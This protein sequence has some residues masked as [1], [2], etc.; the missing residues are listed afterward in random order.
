MIMF[1]RHNSLYRRVIVSVS[2]AVLLALPAITVGADPVPSGEVALG[3][4]V[5]E[6]AYNY[7]DGSITYLLTPSKAQEKANPHTVAPLYLVVYPSAVSGVIG[8]MSCQHQPMDNCPDHG[9]AIS[10]LAMATV[11][12][13]YA[14][15]VWGHDHLI[16]APPS[17]P[18]AGNFHVAWQP[19]VVLFLNAAASSTHITT[20][21]QLKAAILANNVTLVALPA[22]TIFHGSTVAAATY[23]NGTP[24]PP[25]PALP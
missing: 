18:A 12:S 25:A 23:R 4:S 20:M 21:D 13:V 5:I 22:A 11:P 16:A 6:P 3:Q 24:L 10:G 15:G 14:A 19:V 2:M 8:T 1:Q 7:I 9:P 17:P